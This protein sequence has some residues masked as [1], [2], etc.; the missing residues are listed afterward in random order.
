MANYRK[1]AL[2]VT[3][4]AVSAG[5]SISSP[6]FAL[7]DNGDYAHTHATV[8]TDPNLVCGD[9]KCAPGE[10]SHGPSPIV[11]VRGP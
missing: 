7:Q 4:F 8:L 1:L 9:H 10:T 5:L 2:A 3:L 11:P 6:A